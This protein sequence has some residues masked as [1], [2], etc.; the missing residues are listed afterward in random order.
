M[1]SYIEKGLPVWTTKAEAINDQ[2]KRAFQ[3]LEP[4]LRRWKALFSPN[5]I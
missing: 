2:S 5:K 4:T 3:Q 1:L